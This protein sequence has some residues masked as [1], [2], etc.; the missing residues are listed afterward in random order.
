MTTRC[1]ISA[2]DIPWYCQITVATGSGI[3]GKMST[4]VVMIATSPA[5]RTRMAPQMK[6]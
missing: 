3:A 5:M 2:G 4:G 6:V 1:S